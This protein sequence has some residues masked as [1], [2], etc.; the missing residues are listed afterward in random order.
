MMFSLSPRRSSLAPRIAASVSTRVVSWNDAA[1]MNDWVVRL[2]LVMPNSRGSAVAGF[3]LR[4]ITR[5]FS[6]RN[7]SLS[8]AS[9]SRK[10]VSPGSVTRTFWS[11]WRTITPMCLSAMRTPCSRY[12]SW[13]SL[14]R[15][16]CTARGPLISRISW[17]L[18]G[19]SVSRSPARTRSPSCTRRCL[20]AG[21]S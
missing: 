5:S 3:P 7:V 4:R 21:T 17:G 9:A 8:T 20:P 13:T 1:E 15:Y 10:L 18:T 11:I 16:S 14:S 12:T 2:A 19:P 6:S